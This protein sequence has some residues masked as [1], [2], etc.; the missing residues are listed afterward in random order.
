VSFWRKQVTQ[1]A[2]DAETR[3][4]MDIMDVRIFFVGAR[5]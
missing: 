3:R 1:P 4:Q 5:P 2:L